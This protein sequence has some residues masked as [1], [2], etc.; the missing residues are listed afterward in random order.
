MNRAFNDFTQLSRRY[1]N[2]INILTDSLQQFGITYFARQTVSHNG[3]WEIVGN[4][5]EWLEHSAE[6]EFYKIDS[7]LMDPNLY[8]SGLTVISSNHVP[9]F[10]EKMA[11]EARD[12]FDIEHCLCISQ[13]TDVG[14]EWYFFA[15]SAQNTSIYNTYITKINSIYKFIKYFNNEAKPIL[16]ENLDYQIDIASIKS[17]RFHHSNIIELSSPTLSLDEKISDLNI[18]ARESDCLKL[19]L[20][21]KTIKETAKMLTISPRT[22]EDYLNRLKKKLGL[23]YKRELFDLFQKNN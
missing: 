14:S 10:L 20:A 13:K 18:S 5:P 3:Y 15:T 19:V 6:Q 8:Q 16:H 17:E 1:S 11:K 21:G 9:H 2:K 7:S 12:V 4:M 23:K 22:V